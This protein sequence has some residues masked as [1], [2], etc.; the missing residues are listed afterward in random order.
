[1]LFTEAAKP[2][3]STGCM[4]SPLEVAPLCVCVGLMS[5]I[6]SAHA[7]QW[8]YQPKI[9]LIS[10]LDDNLSLRINEKDRTWE[11]SIRPQIKLRSTSER[12]NIEAFARIETIQY[13]GDNVERRPDRTDKRFTLEMQRNYERAVAG[14]NLT[15]VEDSSFEAEL[16]QSGIATLADV[17]RRQA[18]FSP[19]LHYQLTEK[20]LLS[21]TYDFSDV[22]YD[23]I[24]VSRFRDY[25]THSAQA[26]L[27][28]ELS[29][30][31]SINTL[32]GFTRFQYD[33]DRQLSDNLTLRFGFKRSFSETLT[34]S[35]SVGGRRTD[36]KQI[37]PVPIGFTVDGVFVQTR[38]TTV[39]QQSE[40]TGSTFAAN[41][42]KEFET[43]SFN[44]DLSRNI[45]PSGTEGLVVSDQ[46]NVLARH[47]LNDKLT[48]AL[49]FRWTQ[50]AQDNPDLRTFDNEFFSIIPSLTWRLSEMWSLRSSYR[51]REEVRGSGGAKR[52][53]NL[54]HFMLTYDGPNK[55]FGG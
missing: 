3:R 46:F 31:N 50:N 32:L 27:S 20:N 34:A 41:L 25:T 23:D 44:A 4:R 48:S 43:G 15:Y 30:R 51:Y 10:G 33:D 6:P 14:L 18:T 21:L 5:L 39:E 2:P 8:Q 35:L 42:T 17:G 12:N 55:T 19:S 9:S 28:H 49:T 26:F 47:K 7:A 52:K 29:Q 16:A 45:T 22:S 36:S 40:Q 24:P 1:M 53:S 13:N 38:F 54:I 37:V 11:T